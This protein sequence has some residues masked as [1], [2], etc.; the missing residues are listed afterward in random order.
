[1]YIAKRSDG[2]GNDLKTS[3]LSMHVFAHH[4]IPVSDQIP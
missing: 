4:W 3:A 2:V 1:M